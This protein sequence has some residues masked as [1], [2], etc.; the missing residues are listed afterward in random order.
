MNHGQKAKMTADLPGS[1][2]SWPTESRFYLHKRYSLPVVRERLVSVRMKDV[3][4]NRLTAIVTSSDKPCCY[5]KKDCLVEKN[6]G[7]SF[8]FTT[9]YYSCLHHQRLWLPCADPLQRHDVS[10]GRHDRH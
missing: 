1:S 10:A 4:R 7:Q 9:Y 5:L 2:S 6:L 8:Q 3:F